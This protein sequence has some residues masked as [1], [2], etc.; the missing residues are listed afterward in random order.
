MELS[1]EGPQGSVSPGLDLVAYRI[2]QESLTNAIKH[3]GPADARV[4][5]VFGARDLVLEVTDN[6][7]GAGTS[8]P[9][10]RR[11]TRSDRNDASA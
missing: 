2:V 5:V 4:H 10:R 8:P 6:G 1:V 11:W 9:R 7:R 3:A